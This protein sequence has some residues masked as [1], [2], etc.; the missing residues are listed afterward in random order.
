MTLSLLNKISP[1]PIRGFA[2]AIV[3]ASVKYKRSIF[4]VFTDVPYVPD[5]PTFR[6][7]SD[8]VKVPN[9]AGSAILVG[10]GPGDPELLTLKALKAFEYADVVL[11]D[12]LVSEEIL[13]LI[14][15]HTPIEYVGKRAGKHSIAQDKICDRMVELALE[16]KCVVRLKGGDPAIFARTAEETDA[17]T[18]NN[19]PFSIIPGITAASGAS[20]CSGIPLTHRD[21][22][23]SVRFVTATMKDAKQ[24]PQWANLADVLSYQTLVFYMGLSRL[25]MIC[26][27]LV[28]H[29]ADKNTSIALV[30]NASCTN[31]HVIAGT[32]DT[33]GAKMNSENLQGPTLII[34]GDVVQKRSQISDLNVLLAA[35]LGR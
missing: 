34:V 5:V 26:T 33:I 30:E 19:I 27:E 29:G 3:S 31:Q 9:K 11:F 8:T 7:D 15:R 2:S 22:A 32:L 20:A 13:K 1:S 18:A 6:C 28:Q 24:Q 17:L 21:C 23:Q 16:G 25:N 14:P 4:D 35:K 12:S 10:A